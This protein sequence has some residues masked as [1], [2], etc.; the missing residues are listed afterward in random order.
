MEMNVCCFFVVV[1]QFE[2]I[3][4]PQSKYNALYRERCVSGCV[5]IYFDLLCNSTHEWFLFSS[6]IRFVAWPF[7]F[8][9][10]W[11]LRAVQ[12]QIQIQISTL[13]IFVCVW[14]FLVIC[15]FRFDLPNAA[16]DR[17]YVW[18]DVGWI[19]FFFFCPRIMETNVSFAG[20]FHS[21]TRWYTQLL[22]N[23]YIVTISKWC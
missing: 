4:F 10:D 14:A 5:F 12:I 9:R 13:L 11:N 22:S 21:F 16:N 2:K 7:Y 3:V 8:W 17:P 18:L 23:W 15:F 6:F 1:V 19:L 20:V